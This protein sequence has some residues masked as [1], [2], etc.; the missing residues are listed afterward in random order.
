MII[1]KIQLIRRNTPNDKIIIF[2][3][4]NGMLFILERVLKKYNI[5]Y[6]ICDK[7]TTIQQRN[8]IIKSFQNDKDIPIMLMLLQ[9]EE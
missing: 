1:Q 5:N 8:H 9:Y 7:S 3:Q 2:S 6:L 4:F